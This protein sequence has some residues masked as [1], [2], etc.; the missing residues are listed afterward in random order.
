MVTSKNVKKGIKRSVEGKIK[1]EMMR[2]SLGGS[3][4]RPLIALVLGFNGV[5]GGDKKC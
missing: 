3:F 1:D 5:S 4:K 2:R